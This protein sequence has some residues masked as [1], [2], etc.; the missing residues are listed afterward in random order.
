MMDFARFPVP[1]ESLNLIS[2]GF[3][4][5]CMEASPLGKYTNLEVVPPAVKILVGQVTRINQTLPRHAE[6]QHYLRG[7]PQP[8]F[9][10]FHD[11]L[12]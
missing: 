9:S 1:V 6:E 4:H 10:E 5:G 12:L 7:D 8:L 2:A 11:V 3:H